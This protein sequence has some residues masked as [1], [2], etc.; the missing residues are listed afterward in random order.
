MADK[1]YDLTQKKDVSALFPK[2]EKFDLPEGMASYKTRLCDRT[3]CN[4]MNSSEPD[5]C[6]PLKYKDGSNSPGLL[7]AGYQQDRNTPAKES[8][9]APLTGA[10]ST[11][12]L[13]YMLLKTF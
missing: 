7:K 8:G 13:A 5:L 6:A 2:S 12:A 4:S 1:C 9:A 11:L 3:W 10:L